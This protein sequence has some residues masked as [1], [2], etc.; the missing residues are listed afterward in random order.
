[1]SKVIVSG[2]RRTQSCPTLTTSQDAQE[3]SKTSIVS[4]LYFVIE[5]RSHPH[6]VQ[7]FEREN[8]EKY[9]IN[10]PQKENIYDNREAAIFT[11]LSSIKTAKR[12]GL[13]NVL[14]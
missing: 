7:A 1:M 10:D 3:V 11:A 2:E 5:E 12:Q 6:R 8:S 4:V 9:N 14:S 13:C